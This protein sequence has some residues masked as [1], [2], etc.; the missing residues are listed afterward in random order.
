MELSVELMPYKHRHQNCIIDPTLA[1]SQYGVTLIKH[2]GEVMD[3]WV[4]QELW[5]ILDNPTLYLQ[6]PELI[7]PQGISLKRTPEQE[8]IALEETLQSLREWERFRSETDLTKLNLFWLGDS[9]QESLLP[10]SRKLEIFWRW[11]A[12]SHLL[13]QQFAQSQTTDYLLPLAF[14]DTIALALSLESAI[15]LTRLSPEDLD[16]NSPPEICKYL[17]EWDITCKPLSIQDNLVAEE[18][19]Y[20]RQLLVETNTAKV[21]WAGVNL[22]VVHLLS[23]TLPEPQVSSRQ[24]HKAEM[25]AI[26]ESGGHP[27]LQFAHW[28]KVKGFWYLV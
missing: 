5:N 18:R 27:T 1:F 26:Q 14:R 23:L 4:V 9:P 22:A 10:T 12:I 11:E 6:Q 13:N 21:V 8:R 24:I 16:I 15:L 28:N 2:L 25:S 3:L 19:N 20:F 7:T 17:E